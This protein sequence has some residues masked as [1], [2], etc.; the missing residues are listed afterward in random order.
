MFCPHR[1]G[2][3]GRRPRDSQARFLDLRDFPSPRA[4]SA[5]ERNM[6]VVEKGSPTVRPEKPNAPPAAGQNHKALVHTASVPQRRSGKAA[7]KL[8]TLLMAASAA[9]FAISEMF[10]E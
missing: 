9:L 3:Q 6:M 2:R 1:P 5:I 8:R 7:S 10:A 4:M